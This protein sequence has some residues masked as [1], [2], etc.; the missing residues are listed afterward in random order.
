MLNAHANI[1]TCA[2]TTRRQHKIP[3]HIPLSTVAAHLTGDS[4]NAATVAQPGWASS[5]L[6]TRWGKYSKFHAQPHDIARKISRLSVSAP[7]QPLKSSHVSTFP[8]SATHQTA[9]SFA[10]EVFLPRFLADLVPT[11]KST[12]WEFGR[13][14]RHLFLWHSSL[15]RALLPC[16]FHLRTVVQELSLSSL[17]ALQTAWPTAC[18]CSSTSGGYHPPPHRWYRRQCKKNPAWLVSICHLGCSHRVRDSADTFSRPLVS[19]D[20]A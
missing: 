3:T 18:Q 12:S 15:A 14:M 4:V 16:C 6:C 11:L 2:P 9:N 1:Q 19:Y 13:H 20:P 17:N 8:P 5:S 7:L 10:L